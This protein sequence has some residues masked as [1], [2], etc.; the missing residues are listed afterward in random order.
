[1]RWEIAARRYGGMRG[2]DL[3]GRSHQRPFEICLRCRELGCPAGLAFPR[4]MKVRTT[5]KTAPVI[6]RRGMVGTSYD[7]SADLPLIHTAQAG[8][9][10]SLLPPQRGFLSNLATTIGGLF[11]KLFGLEVMRHQLGGESAHHVPETH[12]TSVSGSPF[13]HGNKD[14]GVDVQEVGRAFQGCGNANRS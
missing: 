6:N 4:R 7:R 8:S 9:I 14:G 11:F 5:V 1:M 3:P 2:R 10:V 12:R 13:I